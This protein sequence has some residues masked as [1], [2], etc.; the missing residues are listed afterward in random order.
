MV[1]ANPDPDSDPSDPSDSDSTV[2][3]PS[4]DSGT[5]DEELVSAS[6]SSLFLVLFRIPGL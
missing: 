1:L 5:E 4:S 3:S 6:F 2:N